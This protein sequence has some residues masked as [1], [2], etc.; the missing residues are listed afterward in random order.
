MPFLRP[1]GFSKQSCGRTN[2][3]MIF[4]AIGCV[5][6]RAFR[7]EKQ[8]CDV[9]SIISIPGDLALFIFYALLTPLQTS[10]HEFFFFGRHC[11][12]GHNDKWPFG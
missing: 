4:I 3:L 5:G 12:T 2:P 1:N 10:P 7:S 8:E 6:R 9:K 11:T